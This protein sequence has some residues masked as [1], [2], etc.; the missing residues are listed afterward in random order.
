[1]FE[2]VEAVEDHKGQ[3]ERLKIDLI[4]MIIIL[5]FVV[6]TVAATY[7]VDAYRLAY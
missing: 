2:K 3:N 1:M 5:W 7:R 4:T 6:L